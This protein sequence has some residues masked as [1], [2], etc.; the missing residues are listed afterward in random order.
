MSLYEHLQKQKDYCETMGARPN[1]DTN[2][3]IFYA[4]AA[5]GYEIK[6]NNLKLNEAS[7]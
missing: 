2:L 4:R 1:T 5:R 7:K 6:L 3:R